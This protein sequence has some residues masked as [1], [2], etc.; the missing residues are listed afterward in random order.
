[1][2]EEGTVSTY[3]A[4]N[5]APTSLISSSI[6][7]MDATL[8]DTTISGTPISSWLWVLGEGNTSTS[9]NLTYSYAATGTFNVNLTTTNAYGSNTSEVVIVIAAAGESTTTRN[10]THTYT[11][12]GVYTIT[13]SASNA[14]GTD[15]V[16]SFV[17]VIIPSP[18][19]ASP[20]HKNNP[21]MVSV[22]KGTYTASRELTEKETERVL[23]NLYKQYR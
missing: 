8:N 11:H 10:A 12:P 17:I 20:F 18:E 7:G 6:S 21:L 23:Y 4:T 16:T 15:S 19:Q 3:N 13:H 1:M 9:K 2:L 14:Y 22:Q 5:E